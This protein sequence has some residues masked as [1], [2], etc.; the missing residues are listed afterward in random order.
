MGAI[1]EEGRGQCIRHLL[2]KFTPEY[3]LRHYCQL[4]PPRVKVQGASGIDARFLNQ[5]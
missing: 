1:I 3:D 4:P 2:V 5:I